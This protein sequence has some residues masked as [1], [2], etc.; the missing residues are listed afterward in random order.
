MVKDLLLF[1]TAEF[2]E[3]ADEDG[4]ETAAAYANQAE[5]DNVTALMRA[6]QGGFVKVTP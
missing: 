3:A 2:D 4:G 6:A 5:V 1:R